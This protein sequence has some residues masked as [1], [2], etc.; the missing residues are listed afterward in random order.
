MTHLELRRKFLE[1]FEKR[2]HKVIPSAS[3]VPQN[4][5]TVLFTTAGMQPLVPYLLGQ[6]HPLGKRLVNIQKCLRTDDIEEVGDAIH[7]TFVEMLGNWSLGDYFKEESIEYSYEFLKDVLKLDL[8]RIYFTCF[9]GDGDAPK[10]EVSA[11]KWRGLGISDKHIF[12]YSKKDNWWGPVGETGPCGPDTEMHYDVTQKPHGKDCNPGCSCGRFSEIWNNVFMEYNKNKNGKYEKLPQKNVDTGM[13]LERTLAIVNNL[14]DNYLTELWQPAIKKIEELS[15]KK[16]ENNLKPFRIIADH[17]RAAVFAIADGV[18]PSNKQQGYILRR[19]IRRAVVQAKQIGIP[20]E[21]LNEIANIFIE[22]MSPIYPEL[23]KN[24]IL[25]DE[26]LRFEKTL[27][28][29]LKEFEKLETMTGKDAFNLFQTY[30]FPW[31]I[32]AELAAKRNLKINQ[33]EFA[34]EFKKHQ[35]LSRT[36]SAGMF[37]GG[38]ANHSEIVTKYHTAT[39]LLHAALRKILGDSVHQEGSNLTAERLR[40]DFSFP[41]KVTEEE[42]KKITELVNEQIENEL[43]QKKEVMTYDQAIKSGALAF[44]KEKYPEKVTVYSFGDFSREVC[45]G[46]HA[47]NIKVLGKFKI[48]KQESVSAGVRRIYAQIQN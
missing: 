30:G 15:G 45:G 27:D 5:P 43:A 17:I 11:N 7:H 29:G 21:K 4:D 3:L 42:I 10:D 39:H 14:D 44:F 40:F 18:I 26:I 23:T 12:F 20:P 41:R 22:I 1:F 36:A 2:G 24:N 33:K 48:I 46:P 32:T 28:K 16:Y 37:K 9:A 6:P 13:G 47:E 8:N 31:E 19:L 35:E 34:E 38:L 25:P